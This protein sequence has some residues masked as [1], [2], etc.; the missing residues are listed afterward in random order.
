MYSVSKWPQT[1]SLG[2]TMRR[3]H[4]GETSSLFFFFWC[5]IVAGRHS[6]GMRGLG[7]RTLGERMRSRLRFTKSS[8][9]GGKTSGLGV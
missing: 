2:E 4:G 6:L 8:V 3:A 5:P 9:G 7:E 1:P